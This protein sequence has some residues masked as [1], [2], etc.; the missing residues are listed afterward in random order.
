MPV[1]PP[2]TTAIRPSNRSTCPSSVG[3]RPSSTDRRTVLA[4]AGPDR[5]VRL[6]SAAGRGYRPAH[7]TRTTD[8]ADR[9]QTT[10]AC[11]RRSRWPTC[12][13]CCRRSAMATGDLSLLR[14]DLRIDPLL[15]IEEQGGLTPEQQQQVREL[16]LADADPVPRLAAVSL[17]RHPTATTFHTIV[18]YLAGGLPS[19]EY[20]PM[21]QEEMAL[22]DDFRSAHWR[23]EDDRA[24]PRLPR[25]D[26]RL[27][28]VR[29]R[30]RVPTPAGRR[31]LRR[32]REEPRRR[33]H[34]VRE[35]VPRLSRRHPE[36]L[37]QLLVRAARRLAVLLLAAPGAAPLLRG[38]RRRVRD[39]PEHPHGHRGD[40]RCRGTTSPACGRSSSPAPTAPRSTLTAHAVISAV[41]QLNR[42]SLPTIEGARASPARR[43]TPPSGTTTSTSPA[44][45]SASSAPAA[46]ACAVHPDHRRAGRRSSRSSSARRTGCSPSRTT[47]TSVPEGFQYLLGHVPYYRQL[48]RFWLFWRSAESLRP[49]AEVD[50]SWPRS[51][52]LGQRAQRHDA[53]AAHRGDHGA[54]PRASRPARQGPARLPA[55]G[56]ADRRR[57]RRVRAGAPPRQRRAD[58]DGHRA[59]HAAG[60][61]DRRRRAARVRRADL[62]DRV[63][64][65]AVPDADEGRRARRRRPP[66]LVGRR[67][68]RVP[69]HD[70]ARASRTS[71]CSTGRTRTSSSTAASS[72]SPSAR[73]ATSWTA[74]GRSSPT[75]TRRSTCKPEVHDAYNDEVDA[76]NRRMVWG[77]AD[78]NSWY[79][80]AKGRV[81]AELAVPAA[82]VLEADERQ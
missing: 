16:A 22:T 44:S 36:P 80:N 8:P 19:E 68:P 67:R 34:V 58:D 32:A 2:V 50:P 55:G 72:G 12:R 65:D 64:V 29:N 75:S 25:R 74:S 11:A 70:R 41:G 33:R 17:R 40:A 73:S 21:M 78:V 82:R 15:M 10:S 47:T 5:V 53:P 54:V 57:Q 6:R 30:R 81:D 37:L 7:G 1:P 3:G 18:E 28:H 62:R 49:I 61:R 59:D 31:R 63:P 51:G 56:E 46:R 39:P 79:K 24:E 26:R 45:G 42:P 4:G 38:V 13:R 69:R 35:P 48:Y 43:S 60:R 9:R 23:K 71:S 20:V 76:E 27:R 66:R 77:V 14:P 52:A